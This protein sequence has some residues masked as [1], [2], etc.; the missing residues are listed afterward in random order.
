[1][2]AHGACCWPCHPLWVCPLHRILC[3]PLSSGRRRA[4]MSVA[5]S[6]TAPPVPGDSLNVTC[7]GPALEAGGPE[8]LSG[9]ESTPVSPPDVAARP[10]PAPS[11]A[12]VDGVDDNAVTVVVLDSVVTAADK[13]SQAVCVNLDCVAPGCVHPL[14]LWVWTAAACHVDASPGPHGGGEEERGSVWRGGSPARCSCVPPPPASQPRLL[15]APR[16]GLHR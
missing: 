1:M 3:I 4:P 13:P 16:C 8:S 5:S 15:L 11:P 14:F 6:E 12:R 10:S 7:D 2:W 9:V